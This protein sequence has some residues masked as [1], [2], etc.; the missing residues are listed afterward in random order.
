MLLKD[1]MSEMFPNLELRPPLF[2]GWDIAIRFE[3][4]VEEKREYCNKNSLYLKGVYEKAITLFKSLH[5]DNEEIFVV[6]NVND[7][8]DSATFVKSNLQSRYGNKTK[9][10]SPYFLY[11]YQKRNYFSCLR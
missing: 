10:F 3:L 8:G 7:F 9:H 5:L 2:Y 11:K 1:C 4:G 6:A